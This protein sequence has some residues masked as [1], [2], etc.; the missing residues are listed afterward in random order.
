MTSAPK[1]A[2]S[3]P[4][5]CPTG[6]HRRHRQ[7]QRPPRGRP[8]WSH[9]RAS[10]R[11]HVVPTILERCADDFMSPSTTGPTADLSST[12]TAAGPASAPRRVRDAY[13]AWRRASGVREGAALARER[14]RSDVAGRSA[15]ALPTLVAAVAVALFAASG[16]NA[17]TTRHPILFVHGVEGTG[18]QFES[19]KLRTTSTST[20]R[21]PIREFGPSRSGRASRCPAQQA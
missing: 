2:L 19:Q 1:R 8:A 6:R 3:R 14:Y 4:S 21:A 16:A 10:S 15:A 7:L 12:E 9:P 20:V 11:H 17:A 18:A 13:R 5:R